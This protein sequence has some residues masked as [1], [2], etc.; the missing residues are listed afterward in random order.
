MPKS[1]REH[2]VD[3][4]N[5]VSG[6]LPIGSNE[7][8]AEFTA[9]TG[10]TQKML[11]T[12]WESGSG[13]TCCNEFVSWYSKELAK[14]LEKPVLPLGNFSTEGWLAANRQHQNHTLFDRAHRRDPRL[15]RA[16]RT[17]PRNLDRNQIGS[18]LYTSSVSK[19]SVSKDWYAQG[20]SNP[21]LRRERAPS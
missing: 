18:G 4:L 16:G 19:K 15:M 13:L 5:E 3:I 12:L 21:C 11:T 6:K 7:K 9:Y 1:V 2:A 8:Q 20:E 10:Y 14:R 17:P